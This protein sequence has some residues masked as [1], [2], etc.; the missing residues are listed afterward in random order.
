M[1]QRIDREAKVEA[2]ASEGR[3]WLPEGASVL[4]L[5]AVPPQAR[6][7]ID[8]FA[9][10]VMTYA[11]A[12]RLLDALASEAV[13]V[14]C[15]ESALDATWLAHLGIWVSGQPAWSDLQFV[16][17]LDSASA[18]PR[19]R[20]IQN[21]LEN[22]AF[23]AC[24]D[25]SALQSELQAAGRARIRQWVLRDLLA[26]HHTRGR[27]AQRDV[28]RISLSRSPL[29]GAL[30]ECQQCQGLLDLGGDVIYANSVA[31]AGIEADLQDVVGRPFWECPWFAATSGAPPRVRAA[32][33]AAAAGQ[34]VTQTL[35]LRLPAG[36]KTYAVSIRP[37]L[38]GQG[39]VV[40]LVPEG[41]DVTARERTEE[42]FRHTQKMEA[43]GHLTGE[44][45]HDFNN[46]LAIF[47][48][49][50]DFLKRPGLTKA[51]QQRYV[52]AI[53]N[54]ADRG[55]KLTSHLLSFAHRQAV[56]SKIFD[57]SAS[58][59][60]TGDMMVM[61]CGPSISFSYQA[62]DGP[63]FVDADASQ[64]DTALVNLVVNARDAMEGVGEIHVRVERREWLPGTQFRPKVEMPCVQISVRDTGVGIS[65]D[66]LER[67][68]EPYFTT[69]TVGKGT[70]LG[71]SQV[72]SF[73]TQAGGEVI[74]ESREGEGS[75]FSLFLRRVGPALA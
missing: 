7:T 23:V 31:L 4:L 12:Q 73:A 1:S 30:E 69:K 37:I 32:V 13:A 62:P 53:S 49:S 20:E 39:A 40:A 58:V 22:V 75:T 6:A 17:L 21:T 18:H 27:E 61:L 24:D 52:D 70:G 41:I 56:Q 65:P 2:A 3:P 19:R 8:Q 35:V 38:D 64:F 29:G 51:R 71:L 5:G 48:S 43:I 50:S 60:A 26:Q 28:E 46:L 16:V 55:V 15:T 57:A 72:S 47:K 10:S 54:A 66:K 33:R 34:T 63:C 44:V 59:T 67:I 45:A 25:E 11:I 68:F 42:S 9:P 74:V 36:E 14:I